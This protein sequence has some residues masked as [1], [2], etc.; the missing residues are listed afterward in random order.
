MPQI[1]PFTFG[2]QAVKQGEFAQLTCVVRNGDKPITISWSLKGGSVASDES[3]ITTMIGDRTSMLMI[4]SVDYQHSGIYT[5][6]ASNPAGTTTYSAEL[7]VKGR[8]LIILK[9]ALEI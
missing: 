4:S 9:K 1:L 7:F 3:I 5:C 6:R 2:D 8:N